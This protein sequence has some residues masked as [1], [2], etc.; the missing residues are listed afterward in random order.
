MHT[1]AWN[2]CRFVVYQ[3]HCWLLIYNALFSNLSACG[4]VITQLDQDIMSPNYPSDYPNS[5]TCVWVVKPGQAFQLEF[6]KFNTES[7]YDLLQGYSSLSSF[8]SK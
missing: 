4:G 5:A 3:L 1:L 7:S 6:E 8:D 2:L